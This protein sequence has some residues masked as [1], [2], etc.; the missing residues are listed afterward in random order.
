MP[1]LESLNEWLHDNLPATAALNLT[2]TAADDKGVIISAPFLDNKNHHGTVFG[3]SIAL[4]TTTAAWLMAYISCPDAGGNIVI[5]NSQ[6]HYLKPATAD[7]QG[8][9]HAICHAPASDALTQCH[10][11]LNHTGKGRLTLTTELL[12]TALDGSTYTAARMVGE[13]VMI[14]K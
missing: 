7:S 6:L 2:V 9:I 8:S 4:I 14:K 13:F 5:K 10:D 1:T 3:G 11:A 12:S